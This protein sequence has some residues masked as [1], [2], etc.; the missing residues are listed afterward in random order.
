MAADHVS[1]LA[2]AWA[3]ARDSLW[4]VPSLSVVVGT[5]LAMMA[6]QVPTPETES[7]LARIWLFGGGAEGARGMLSAIAGSLIT[8]TGVV[9]SVTIVALQ[10]ASSQFTPRVLGSFVADRVNQTVLG[11]FI[12]TFTYTLLVLR[13]IRSEAD[14]RNALVPHV[15]VTLA[16]VLLLVSIAALIVF[17]NHAAR[18][19]QASVILQRETSRTLARVAVLFPE[20][21]GHPDDESPLNDALREPVAGP[22]AH[23]VASASGYLQAV[24]AS[25]LWKL[26][27]ARSAGPLTMRMELDIGAF[28]FPGMRLATV[29]PAEALDEHAELAVRTAFVLGAER[30]IE[31][32]IEFGLIVISDIALR[33]LSPGINDPTT[34]IQCID[35]LTEV[36]AALG[37]R[38]RPSEDRRSPD[39]AVRLL[40]RSTS[41]PRALRLAF[42]QIRLFGAGNPAVASR[43]LEALT[44]LA[45]VVPAGLHAHLRHQAAA[46]VAEARRLLDDP[47][48]R[49]E[50]A[51]VAVAL[52]GPIQADGS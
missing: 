2:F 12:G 24:D 26:R 5:V 11:V 22:S 8:V 28:A 45:T 10:L 48:D 21:V 44:E 37:T 3:R 42:D 30:T 14:D 29:W 27:S 18:S 40:M 16:L 7:R 47:G 35:R 39:G 17:I 43:L 36:L 4:F 50:I 20:Q 34:A 51:R 15:A 31:Q 23:V 33:A 32:D 9:F 25:A 6:V 19:I 1:R 49:D 13:T 46:T 52:L 38:R 41:F